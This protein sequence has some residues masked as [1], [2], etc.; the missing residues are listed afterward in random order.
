V[1]GVRSGGDGRGG[2][3]CSYL[4]NNR[5]TGT[6]PASLSALTNLESL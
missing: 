4:S 5:I 2:G 3:L 1:R 6:V